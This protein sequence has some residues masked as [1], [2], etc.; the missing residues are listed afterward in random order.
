[1]S[2]GFMTFTR[3]TPRSDRIADGTTTNSHRT[4]IPCRTLLGLPAVLL[5]T[6]TK[7]GGQ[8]A[9]ILHAGWNDPF[10]SKCA[11]CGC[12]PLARLGLR[13]ALHP[14]L[15]SVALSRAA[16]TKLIRPVLAQWETKRHQVG[17][18]SCK[19]KADSPCFS[20]DGRR[21]RARG[22]AIR[23][24]PGVRRPLPARQMAHS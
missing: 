5:F 22:G 8:T 21:I 4:Q 2:S 7:N 15:H 23:A 12:S 3:P 6:P 9:A 10:C 1:M 17:S 18:W 24:T 19:D 14:W 20:P 16:K 11:A 13:E